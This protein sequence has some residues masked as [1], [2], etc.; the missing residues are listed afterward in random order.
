[1]QSDNG[2]QLKEQLG[3]EMDQLEERVR[4]GAEGGPQGAN[5]VIESIREE[6]LQG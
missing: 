3:D 6:W 1:L 5:Q 4:G 2:N